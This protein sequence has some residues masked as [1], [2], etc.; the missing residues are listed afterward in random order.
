MNSAGAIRD[1]AAWSLAIH[2]FRKSGVM[3]YLAIKHLH[4][5]C[6]VLSGLGFF[7]RGVW[8]WRDSPWLRHRLARTLPH[9]N[10]TL[11]FAAAITLAM[12][13]GQYPFVEPWLTAKVGG[14]LVYILLGFI[15]LKEAHP[16]R[17]RQAAWLA[18]LLTFGYIVSVAYVRDPLG[19]LLW[20]SF[21]PL[22]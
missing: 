2:F 20:V 7:V 22:Y 12:M 4:V 6:V 14:L 18:A 16:K 10:D 9:V 21:A 15:A 19:P 3:L 11:L 13:S 1:S 17:V 8:M 5:S